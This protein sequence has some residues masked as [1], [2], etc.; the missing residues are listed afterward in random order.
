MDPKN[1]PNL[2]PKLKEAYE[3]VMG[4]STTPPAV[5]P[6]V[7]PADA[8][9]APSTPTPPPPA[10]PPA[11][12]Q[13]IPQTVTPIVTPPPT[14]TQTSHVHTTTSFVAADS[15][16]SSAKISPIILLFAGV[17][18]FLVYAVFWLKFFNLPLPFLSL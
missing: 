8:A 16:K 17:I 7:H 6:A 3:R 5:P 11:P 15:T 2:D 13:P 1:L 9:T 4:T 18:F 14:T 12:T 10:V